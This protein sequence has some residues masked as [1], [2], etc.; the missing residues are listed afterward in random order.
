M[1]P[2]DKLAVGWVNE[3]IGQG[4]GF[5]PYFLTIVVENRHITDIIAGI[6]NDGWVV[7]A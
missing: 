7:S 1:Q 3:H 4:N 5:Q 6:R 2:R